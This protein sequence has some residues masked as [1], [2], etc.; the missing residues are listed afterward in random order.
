[1]DAAKQS[2]TEKEPYSKPQVTEIHLV[3]GEAVL[4]VC[5]NAENGHDFCQAQG[6]TSCTPSAAP[7]S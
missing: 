1:M 5:K 6:D 7:H 4:G 2:K 3:A